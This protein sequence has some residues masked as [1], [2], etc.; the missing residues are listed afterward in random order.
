MKNK[1]NFLVCVH[2]VQIITVPFFKKLNLHTTSQLYPRTLCMVQTVHMLLSKWDF[3]SHKSNSVL[4]A[5][6]AA[7]CTVQPSFLAPFPPFCSYIHRVHTHTVLWQLGPRRLGPRRLG[8]RQLGPRRL[9]PQYWAHWQLGPDN[10]DQLIP[11]R[12]FLGKNL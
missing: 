4:L 6:T 1:A 10:T 9:G 8:P 2:F 12:D 7:Y 5:A 11:K 3:A